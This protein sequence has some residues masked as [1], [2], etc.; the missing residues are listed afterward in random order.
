MA[1]TIS[2]LADR[3]GVTPDT[4]RYYER[5]GLLPKPPRGSNGYRLYDETLTERL[6]F[7][8]SAQH[9]GLRLA[10]V[11]E[12]LEM[13]DRGACPC[14]HTAT[15]VDRRLAAVDAEVRRL[16]TMRERLRALADRNEA[17]T[18]LDREVWWCATSNVWKGGEP[19]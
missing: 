5:R 8:K 14:G 15:I 3:V 11:K 7:I 12:L 1:V 6:I 2:E 16:R 19:S 17:C 18:G 4:L 9:I 10:D 13:M